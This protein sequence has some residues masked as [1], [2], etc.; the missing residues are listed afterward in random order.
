MKKLILFIF[1]FLAIIIQETKGQD[2]LVILNNNWLNLKK[3]LLRRTDIVH[4]LL[5]DIEETV[6]ADLELQKTRSAAFGLIYLK[7]YV[8]SC[9][10]AK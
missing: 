9:A 8:Y 3:E 6:K 2:S 10:S 7:F 5:T 1:Y 4:V